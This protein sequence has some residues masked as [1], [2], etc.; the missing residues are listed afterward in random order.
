MPSW[1]IYSIV[2]IVLWGVW[3]LLL[4][5]SY[6][7]MAWSD[8]YFLS[9]LASFTLSITIYMLIG[10][11]NLQINAIHYIPLLAGLFGGLGYVFFIKALESGSASIIIPLTAIYPALT[12]ILAIIFLGEKISIH[13]VVGIILALTAIVLL[14]IE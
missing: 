12:T 14:S 10:S 3:G 6:K 1:L 5:I 11:K 9:T 7:E 4:K 8:V 13:Q 2:C